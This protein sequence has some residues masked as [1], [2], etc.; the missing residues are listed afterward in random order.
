MSPSS[1]SP[2]E[3]HLSR[4]DEAQL[5]EALD[6]RRKQIDRE[7]SEFKVEKEKEFWKFEKRLRS[8]KRDAERQKILQC[9]REVGK[10]EGKGRRRGGSSLRVD[11]AR[12]SAGDNRKNGEGDG[13]GSH[14]RGSAV[15]FGGAT[16][17]PVESDGGQRKKENEQPVHEREV[18][19]QG[20]FTP[21]YLPL[22]SGG[23]RDDD[24]RDDM[25]KTDAEAILQ[26]G[27]QGQESASNNAATVSGSAPSKPTNPR[28]LSS[29]DPRKMSM[30]ARRSSSRSD[31]SV[32]SLRSSIRDPKQTRS[33]KRVLFSID[34]VVVSPSTSPTLQRKINAWRKS[35]SDQFQAPATMSER[36]E[37]IPPYS[38]SWRRDPSGQS[39]KT[40]L[41]NIPTTSGHVNGSNKAHHPAAQIR[42]PSTSPSMGGDGFEHIRAEEDDD[43]FPFD[44]DLR[45]QDQEPQEDQAGEE[46]LR[47][48]ELQ[49]AHEDLSTSSPH[50]GSLP[51]EIK[52]PGM[53]DP[54][55]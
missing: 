8:E 49:N 28:H 55:G 43:L 34:N 48:K 30:S 31:T 46:E 32:S 21:T 41:T 45:Y 38:S 3:R 5:A 6:L 37:V 33:P 53:K 27:R 17:I 44:E 52:W 16:E 42:R 40:A 12:E 10:V 26:S 51:I 25:A 54:R 23:Q 15:R 1:S 47:D 50:A 29:S 22:L 18:A 11:G 14:G 19:F 2:L 24:L 13:G 7:I 39:S 9:E 4:A 36:V 35:G 20:L